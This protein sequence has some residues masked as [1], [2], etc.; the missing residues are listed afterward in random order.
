MKI[1][2]MSVSSLALLL[3]VTVV[4]LGC[5][6]DNGTGG[7]GGG[8]DGDGSGGNNT[9]GNNNGGNDVRVE[10]VDPSTVVK[11]SFVDIRDGQ[12]YK[13]V[14]IGTQTWMA[15]NLNY[16]T[17]SSWCY[18]HSADSCAKYGR[19]YP[20]AAAMTVCPSGWKLP[21]TTDWTRLVLAV[22]GRDTTIFGTP[23]GWPTWVG[24]ADKLKT[25]D[26]WGPWYYQSQ[27]GTDDYGFSAM[28]GGY[29]LYDD[30]N[31]FMYAGGKGYW[32][33]ASITGNIMGDG[34]AYEWIMSETN[35]SYDIITRGWSYLDSETA[36]SVRCIKN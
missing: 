19:L 6:G 14:K 7:S 18:E 27:G 35:R 29:F 16:Q 15:Q 5:G 26:G 23:V 32:W 10:V 34:M 2:K 28:S 13:T 30:R 17:D 36:E 8:G 11:D 25:T 3:S 20:W 31:Y 12:T 24:A 1:L 33:S 9:G 21:D 22:G 4:L